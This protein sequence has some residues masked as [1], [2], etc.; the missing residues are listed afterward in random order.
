[1][2]LMLTVFNSFGGGSEMMSS[3]DTGGLWHMLESSLAYGFF[4]SSSVTRFPD[5]S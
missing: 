4:Q 2:F 3:G 1:M 5:L